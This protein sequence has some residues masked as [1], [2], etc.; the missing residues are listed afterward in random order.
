MSGIAY[1]GELLG[2]ALDG[3]CSPC[4]TQG[5]RQVVNTING[6]SGDVILET[7]SGVSGT[8]AIGIGLSEVTV[9]FAKAFSATPTLIGMSVVKGVASDPDVSAWCAKD[10]TA[11]GFIAVLS[12]VATTT[13]YVLHWEV[14][15]PNV[16]SPSPT[17]STT[18]PAM[19]PVPVGLTRTIWITLRTDGL[20]GTGTANDPFD[21]STAAKFDR[22]MRDQAANFRDA[23]GNTLPL[24][25]FLGPGTFLTRGEWH[26]TYGVGFPGTYPGTPVYP[27]VDTEIGWLV[28]N[29]WIIE[30]SGIGV[31]IVK[32]EQWP[33]YGGPSFLPSGIW[34]NA[35]SVIAGASGNV[36]YASH[37]AQVLDL[38]VDC[39][40]NAITRPKGIKL[41][42]V[43]L[44]GKD[45]RI[46]RVGVKRAYG[47]NFA[48]QTGV[49]TSVS[50]P[51][52]LVAATAH[53]LGPNDAVV[54]S[55]A[56]TAVSVANPGVVTSTAHGR[57]TGEVLTISGVVNV[58]ST[59][60]INGS[61][62]VT[63]IDVNQF[64]L[65]GVNVTATGAV[66]ALAL[67]Q[68]ASAFVDIVNANSFTIT[69][70]PVTH[71]GSGLT[72]NWGGGQGECFALHHTLV[73][74]VGL[75]GYPSVATDIT[76]VVIR[77]CVADEWATG[78]DYAIAMT[79]SPGITGNGIISGSL[80][81]DIGTNSKVH[82]FGAGGLGSQIVHNRAENVRALAHYDSLKV[83]GLLISH[84]T[85]FNMHGTSVSL[86][87]AFAGAVYDNITVSENYFV[88]ETL[89]ASPAAWGLV[90]TFAGTAGTSFK[91]L[92]IRNNIFRHSGETAVGAYATGLV[93]SGIDGLIIEGN[94]L[95]STFDQTLA[96]NTKVVINGNYTE[97][98]NRP[99]GLA[100]SAP[101]EETVLREMSSAPTNPVDGT[102]SKLYVKG[103]KLIISYNHSGTMKYRV[104]DL[105]SVDAVWAYTTVAP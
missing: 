88:L 32:L 71:A 38:T 93:I 47:K 22:I 35:H 97:L 86:T 27:G 31:T 56:I 74:A 61:H 51:N 99:E 96:T 37:R 45:A 98:G 105:T 101:A 53:S 25:V 28:H 44:F 79:I 65:N 49:S 17:A 55:K 42:A 68:S 21:G 72:I 5:R 60:A 7:G 59:P 15:D 77:D 50:S 34:P 103:D 36:G 73:E 30:G 102:E 16:V 85:A 24:H 48:S 18:T 13:N 63:V 83:S 67:W 19:N 14:R 41:N 78:N 70:V 33:T 92:V 43:K 76:G 26:Y 3:E 1:G 39:N 91:N 8:K 87:P 64:A 29:D 4:G 89:L 100:N 9:T 58:T 82:A 54:F 2:Y 23:S 104:L 81:Q 95:H 52:G 75:A 10:L 84:N 62:T 20:S 12:T 57:R 6:L 11:T 69:G 40:A 46:E 66:G 94:M 90:A 80:V